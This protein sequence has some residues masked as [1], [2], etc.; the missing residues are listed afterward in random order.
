LNRK[1]ADLANKRTNRRKASVKH[2]LR[3][4][5][6]LQTTSYGEP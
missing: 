3:F 6:H 1:H 5:F 4:G 2:K